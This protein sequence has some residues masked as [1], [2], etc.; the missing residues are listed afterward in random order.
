MPVEFLTDEQAEAYGKFADEPTRPD[1][2][3]LF[4]GLGDQRSSHWR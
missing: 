3:R 2:E 4:F 1:L